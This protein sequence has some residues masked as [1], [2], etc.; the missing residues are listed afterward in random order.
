M[1]QH[2]ARI[3]PLTVLI[4]PN[5]LGSESALAGSLPIAAPLSFCSKVTLFLLSRTRVFAAEVGD[6]SVIATAAL[7][8][9]D[10]PDETMAKVDVLVPAT[11][12]VG[13][14]SVFPWPKM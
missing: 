12:T 2:K 6:R 8:A 13:V 10:T 4:G 5:S 9:A 14:V 11:S 3:W 7:S 1:A